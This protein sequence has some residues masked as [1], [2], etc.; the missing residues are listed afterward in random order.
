MS[1]DQQNDESQFGYPIS[2][3][4]MGFDAAEHMELRSAAIRQM[5]A[6]GE[7]R[8]TAIE[9]VKKMSTPFLIRYLLKTFGLA[10]EPRLNGGI[11]PGG[12]GSGAVITP[13]RENRGGTKKNVD[14]AAELSIMS[15]SLTR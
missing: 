6:G 1:N 8:A 3:G 4:R 5:V 15:L 9:A 13:K 7:D 14:S 11:R 10:I 12:F 2:I